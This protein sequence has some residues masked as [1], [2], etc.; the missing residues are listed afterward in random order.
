MVGINQVVASHKLNIIPMA[1]PVRQKVR[2]FH[3]ESHQIIQTEVDNLLGASFIREVKFPEWLANAVMVPKKEGKW[4]V[5]V[6]YIN[7]NQ[8]CSK[9]SFPLQRINQIVNAAIKHIILSF[10]DCEECSHPSTKPEPKYEPD[11]GRGS[12]FYES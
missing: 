7:L 11:L 4:R 8:A 2:R 6:D 3:L 9:D 10:M 5:C 12:L 1:R